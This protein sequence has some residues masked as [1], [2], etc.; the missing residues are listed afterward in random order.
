MGKYN[1]IRAELSSTC[2]RDPTWE[3]ALGR[4]LLL[5]RQIRRGKVCCRHLRDHL[6]LLQIGSGYHK[7]DRCELAM[8]KC[9]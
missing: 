1:S 8:S 7:A 6:W 2:N 5:Q 3:P 9:W 4:E